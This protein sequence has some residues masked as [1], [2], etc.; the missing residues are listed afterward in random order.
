MSHSEKRKRDYH[1]NRLA[2]FDDAQTATL[3]K[4]KLLEHSS[5]FH[6]EEHSCK[7]SVERVTAQ[8]SPSASMLTAKGDL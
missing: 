8:I 1:S 4:D 3:I 5:E 6:S 2:G 7:F